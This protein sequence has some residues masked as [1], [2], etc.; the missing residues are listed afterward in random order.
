MAK[1]VHYNEAP[2]SLFSKAR[3]EPMSPCGLSKNANPLSLFTRSKKQ[4]TCKNC[5][6]VMEVK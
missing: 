4:V 2:K 5:K 6:M 1:V 3:L